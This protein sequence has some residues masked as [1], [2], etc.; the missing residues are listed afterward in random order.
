MLW[1]EKYKIGIEK[2]DQ[3]HY[4]WIALLQKFADILLAGTG[5]INALSVLRSASDYTRY[6]FNNEEKLMEKYNYPKIEHH[7]KQHAAMI[8]QLDELEKKLR[9]SKISSDSGKLNKNV[10]QLWDTLTRWLANH[11]E[12]EDKLYVPYCTPHKTDSY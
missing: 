8:N 12:N 4:Q 7:K 3:E 1:D 9:E 11:I 5:N 2:I 10:Y 6:H